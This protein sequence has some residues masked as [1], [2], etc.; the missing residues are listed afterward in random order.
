M[1]VAQKPPLEDNPRITEAVARVEAEL[2]EEGRVVLRYSGTES[3]CRVM[4][5]A[6]DR[7]TVDRLVDEMVDVVREELGA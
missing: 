6:P 3:L 7:A 2:G 4:V 1:R 5:E